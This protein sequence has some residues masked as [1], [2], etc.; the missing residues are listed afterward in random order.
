MFDYSTLKDSTSETN[1]HIK[2]LQP[3]A[4]FSWFKQFCWRKQPHWQNLQRAGLRLHKDEKS[5]FSQFESVLFLLFHFF[6]K[7]V[8]ALVFFHL[9]RIGKCIL[10]LL[11]KIWWAI[12]TRTNRYGTSDFWIKLSLE[13][14][15]QFWL[16]GDCLSLK[17]HIFD[18]WVL[19]LG[20][21]LYILSRCYIGEIYLLSTTDFSKTEQ[22][23]RIILL[24]FC[25]LSCLGLFVYFICAI[26]C[27]WVFFVLIR[28]F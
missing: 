13:H 25:W 22:N 6:K 24:A 11:A 28:L 3:H 2:Q 16:N 8:R 23:N 5:Y 14:A 12:P 1:K 20:Q 26:N 7:G 15:H 4:A 18:I 9:I 27:Y 19:P 21:M 10:N 17:V